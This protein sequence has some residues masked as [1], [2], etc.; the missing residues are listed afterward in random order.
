MSQIINTS[1]ADY[2]NNLYDNLS[3]VDMNI[4]S[5]LLFI[6]ITTFVILIYTYCSIMR[7]SADI[8]NNWES[9]RCKPSVI[10]FAGIINKPLH[11][12][13]IEFTANNFNHCINNILFANFKK[14][15]K[16][17]DITSYLDTISIQTFNFTLSLDFFNKAFE[18]AQ[19]YINDK[20]ESINNRFEN[21]SAQ[22]QIIIY[23]VKDILSR[24]QSILMT[25]VYTNLTNSYIIKS[26]MTEMVKYVSNIFTSLFIFIGMLY[27]FPMTQSI[28]ATV[29][30]I[31]IPL[32]IT[33]AATNKSLGKIF[34]IK[35]G[36]MTTGPKIPKCFDKN[37][38]ITMNDGT[39]QTIENI[40]IGD[41]L[42]SNNTVTATFKLDATDVIMCNLN[43][44][45]VSEHHGVL[46]NS[47]WISVLDHPDKQILNNYNEPF[48]YCLNTT[49]KN[50]TIQE[51]V[52]LDWDELYD[53]QLEDFLFYPIPY[54]DTIVSHKSNIHKY[55]DG[56]FIEN[57]KIMKSDFTT[58]FI[59]DIKIGDIL[60][61][62]EIVYGMVEIK[63]DDLIINEYNLGHKTKIV[64]GP[65]LNMY[66]NKKMVCLLNLEFLIV[67]TQK[68]PCKKLYHLL[69]DR[70]SFFVGSVKFCDYNSLID[71]ILN[72]STN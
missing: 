10:P 44:T 14:S 27:V 16:V 50:I 52:Y 21:I 17:F 71:R 49:N 67:E 55:L 72:S 11:Q 62:G 2:I 64:G 69:T 12:S 9:E 70:G 31:T 4:S 63:G 51:N 68:Q 5:I 58:T 39:F 59:Q 60:C 7:N 57:T 48:I 35:P 13:I 1:S 32:A 54:Y 45:I 20:F 40:K 15:S 38:L 33:F 65:N 36:K 23:A 56:G 29:S 18:K 37:S 46:Y 28:A 42:Y 47:K 6:F 26:M 24:S 34:H 66:I 53:S 19:Q 43:G 41:I 8:K 30:A 3:F 25:G 22:I 61:N